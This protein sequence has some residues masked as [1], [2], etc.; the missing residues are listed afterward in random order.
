MGCIQS[1]EAKKRSKRIDEMLRHDELQ[2]AREVKLLLLGAGESGKSTL[3]RQMRILHDQGF[4]RCERV[5]FKPVIYSNILQSLTAIIR[6]MPTLNIPFLDEQLENDA[7][8]FLAF[9]MD[10]DEIPEEMVDIMKSIW[11]NEQIQKGFERSREYQLNDS[12][13]YYLNALDRIATTF[14]IPTQDDILRARV[15][16]T[17]IVETHFVYKD[18]L[19]KMFDVGGQRSERKKWIH[20]FEDVTAVMFCVALSEYDMKLAEDAKMNR[21]HES[22]QLFDSICNNHWF[23]ETAIILFLN[24]TDLF[25]KQLKTSSIRVCFTDYYGDNSFEDTAGFI[26]KE[27]RK[28]KS[29]R[30]RG[31]YTFH[32]CN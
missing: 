11:K 20:C 30:K 12:A 29:S 3:V 7:K 23:I 15:K 6:A 32:M 9:K 17:G 27:I 19:F 25:A 5:A 13:Q 8:T 4:E 18:L 10:T 31:L 21:M 28:T 14:Y 26:R 22:M 2:A 24:K 1:S 16:S